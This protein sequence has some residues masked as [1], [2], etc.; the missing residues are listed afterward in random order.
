MKSNLIQ[1]AQ[2][3]TRSA[4]AALLASLAAP[5]LGQMYCGRLS[6]GTVFAAS[7]VLSALLVPMGLVL[8]E[9]E[10][11]LHRA[12]LPAAAY[13]IILLACHADV[14][15]SARGKPD[16]TLKRY[17]SAWGYALFAL[18]VFSL[19]AGALFFSLSFYSLIAVPGDSM[20]PSF[21]PGEIALLG[22]PPGAGWKPGDAVVFRERGTM[23]FGRIIAVADDRVERA[24][25]RMAVNGV[26]LSLGIYNDPELARFGTA[27]AE[28]VFYEV[29]GNRRYPVI[30]PP[31]KSD[32]D[33]KDIPAATVP[34]GSVMIAFDNRAS[35]REPVTAEMSSIT[36]RLEGVIWPATWRRIFLL[37]HSRL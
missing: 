27:D 30:Q 15:L 33:W 18:P 16:R 20:A 37:P 32:R 12:L 36:G 1:S 4:T 2:R 9:G 14:F 10:P 23:T 19:L 34:K 13:I 11:S 5:G 3:S 26:P 28:S 35:L 6:R 7:L 31:E 17:N 22:F 21:Q 8:R 24:K 25:G 29:N